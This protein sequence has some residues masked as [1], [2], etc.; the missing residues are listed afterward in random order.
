MEQ[1]DKSALIKST[2]CKDLW[3]KCTV[4][5]KIKNSIKCPWDKERSS[6]Q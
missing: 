6:A 2:S 4:L 1:N 5:K 3:V